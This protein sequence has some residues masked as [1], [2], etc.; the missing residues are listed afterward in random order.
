[1]RFKK[2]DVVKI[3][4]HAGKTGTDLFIGIIGTVTNPE[5]DKRDGFVC[6]MV[7]PHI[8]A[9]EHWFYEHNLSNKDI[10]IKRYIRLMKVL[11]LML[12]SIPGI[13]QHVTKY[14]LV[15]TPE[16]STSGLS[17]KS[18]ELDEIPTFVYFTET[19]IEISNVVVNETIYL[20]R[21][22]DKRTF[23]GRTKAGKLAVVTLLY[24]RNMMGK[25]MAVL[26]ISLD[27]EYLL[28]PEKPFIK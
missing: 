7:R 1:M 22:L 12:L 20:D 15:L 24:M 3:T 25:K 10:L 26:R 6:V 23:I 28:F 11:V 16:I 19:Y 18:S 9:A 21:S 14:Q 5:Y 2:G 17:L 8:N 4:G 13:A 27:R